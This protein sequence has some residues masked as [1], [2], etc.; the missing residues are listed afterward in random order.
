[1]AMLPALSTLLAAF[2]GGVVALWLER[3]R[4]HVRQGELLV[5]I[6]AEIVA[7]L[8][9]VEEQTT[10]EEET[11]AGDDADPFGVPDDTDFVF[12]SIKDNPAVLPRSV[13]HTVVRYYKLAEQSNAMT[14]AL[15]D[16]AFRAQPS[17]AKQKYVR[18]LI[19]LMREQE[20]AAARALDEIETE[21]EVRGEP[22][23]RSYRSRGTVDPTRS[24]A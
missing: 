18:Q 2:V 11:Y 7:G 10:S 8:R 15:V 20:G 24:G 19:D 9:R 16:T 13:I 17:A 23:L 22:E 6:H 4:L 5:A 1:M 12:A 21:V 3:R 14:R